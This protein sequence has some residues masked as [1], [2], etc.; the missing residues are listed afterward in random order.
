[1]INIQNAARRAYAPPP[2]HAHHAHAI[3]S[4]EAR[5]HAAR[6]TSSAETHRGL[7]RIV[8]DVQGGVIRSFVLVRVLVEMHCFA[9]YLSR[10]M[11]CLFPCVIVPGKVALDLLG[12]AWHDLPAYFRE[13]P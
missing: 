1:M 4:V 6:G 8:L 12:F 9:R 10:L 11:P 2:P 13:L 7:L 5:P 3:A